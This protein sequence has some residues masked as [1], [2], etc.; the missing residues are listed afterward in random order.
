LTRS[1]CKPHSV[2]WD[3]HLDG[4]LSRLSVA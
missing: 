1:A 3:T 4:H 2:R